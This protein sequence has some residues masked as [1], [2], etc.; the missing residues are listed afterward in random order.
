MKNFI[1]NIAAIN[2]KFKHIENYIQLA[3]DYRVDISDSKSYIKDYEREIIRLTNAREKSKIVKDKKK[4]E[5]NKL[6]E[7]SLIKSGFTK[8][9]LKDKYLCKYEK[10]Y[11]IASVVRDKYLNVNTLRLDED[12]LLF[13]NL[14][15]DKQIKE[16]LINKSKYTNIFCF[17]NMDF[18]LGSKN[19]LIVS[20][21]G[22][23]NIGSYRHSSNI[24]FKNLKDL[25]IPS[26]E[27]FIEMSK[28][29]DSDTILM[30][31]QICK[32]LLR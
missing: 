4:S 32:T 26:I 10:N 20:D 15:F 13:S 8:F 23:Y 5:L 27:N 1:E 22:M 31:Q 9:K 21:Y 18:C 28:S 24:R 11:F 25:D 16:H 12:Y 2:D 17:I 3:Y 14:D 19:K 29:K 30:F 7:G 6:L